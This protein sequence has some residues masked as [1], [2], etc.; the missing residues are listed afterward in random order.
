M[1]LNMSERLDIYSALLCIRSVSR[2]I[3]LYGA[4]GRVTVAH[5]LFCLCF[6]VY[7]QFTVWVCK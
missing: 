5:R 2:I 4:K 7:D 3:D 6:L 1:G